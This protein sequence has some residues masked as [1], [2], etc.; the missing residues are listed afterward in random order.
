MGLGELERDGSL[1]V[2]VG[3]ALVD[4]PPAEAGG[5]DVLLVDVFADGALLPRIC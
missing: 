3:D 2:T 5:L 4:P 1:E